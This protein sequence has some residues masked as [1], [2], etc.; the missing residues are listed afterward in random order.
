MHGYYGLGL[1]AQLRT[2]YAK[3]W[4]Q[5]WGRYW[6][7]VRARVLEHMAGK[8]RCVALHGHLK[9]R[10]PEML[11]H[12]TPITNSLDGLGA[13]FP[14]EKCLNLKLNCCSLL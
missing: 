6:L 10:N 2:L 7:L 1:E 4:P 8:R 3:R 9:E 5:T 13:L 14:A 11:A 12:Q